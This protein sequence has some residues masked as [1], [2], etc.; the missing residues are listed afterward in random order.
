MNTGAAP[1]WCDWPGLFEARLRLGRWILG[2]DPRIDKSDVEAVAHALDDLLA[3]P[4]SAPAQPP[5]APQPAQSDA[6]RARA[7][8]GY[9]SGGTLL[10]CRC[11]ILEAEFARV[12]AEGAKAER[13]RCALRLGNEGFVDLADAI[14]AGGE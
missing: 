14:R 9:H 10:A 8:C 7:L 3:P 4:T 13:E 2:N 6:E 11:A 12:R 5:P 1:A